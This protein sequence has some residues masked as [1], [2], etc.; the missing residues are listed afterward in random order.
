MHQAVRT[1]SLSEADLAAACA[2]LPCAGSWAFNPFQEAWVAWG[3]GKGRS[4]RDGRHRCVLGGVCRA[5][6]RGRRR[7]RNQQGPWQGKLEGLFAAARSAVQ[8]SESEGER[9][10][11]RRALGGRACRTKT[12]GKD[13]AALARL[14]IHTKKTRLRSKQFWHDSF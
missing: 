1:H 4:Y 14:L 13:L 3:Q 8:L 10:L 6:S 9:S 12:E 7:A 2:F 5:N 11:R